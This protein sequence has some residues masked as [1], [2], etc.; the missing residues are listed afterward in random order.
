VNWL[1]IRPRGEKPVSIQERWSAT[2]SLLDREAP[3]RKADEAQVDYL[4]RLSRIGKRYLPL[5]EPIT[6]VRFSELPDDT[7]EQYSELCREAVER[8]L[9]RV[10]NMEP[11]T[12]RAI[13]KIDAHTGRKVREWIGPDSFCSDPRYGHLPGRKV[14]QIVRPPPA[15]V[16][17]QSRRLNPRDGGAYAP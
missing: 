10:D 9:Y 7:V 16:L 13:V 11:H 12:Y 15:E 6:E 1:D 3:I 2:F 4:R 14:L 8:N 5:S 17:Y